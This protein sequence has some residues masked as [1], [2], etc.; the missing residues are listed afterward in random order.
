LLEITE[1][2]LPEHRETRHAAGVIEHVGSLEPRVPVF[3]SNL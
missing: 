3:V 2:H 1:A